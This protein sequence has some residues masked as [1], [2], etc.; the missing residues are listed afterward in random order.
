MTTKTG[1]SRE[2][3]ASMWNDAVKSA[4]SNGDWYAEII[5]GFANACFGAGAEAEREA[6]ATHFEEKRGMEMFCENVAD[7]IRARS[8]K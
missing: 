6:L 4:N 1:L 5:T 3:V 7:A 2:E 8:G